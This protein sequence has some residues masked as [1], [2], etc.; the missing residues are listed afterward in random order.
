MIDHSDIDSELDIFA[1][2]DDTVLGGESLYCT[3][4]EEIAMGKELKL[5]AKK[6]VLKLSNYQIEQYSASKARE[7]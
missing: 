2:D 7:N 4:D 1:N 3:L 5:R 6:Y